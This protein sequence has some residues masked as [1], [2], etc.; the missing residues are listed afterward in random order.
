MFGENLIC[1]VA[2]DRAAHAVLVP[3]MLIQPLLENALH[4]GGQTSRMPLKVVVTTKVIDGLLEVV[5]ANTG[6]WDEPDTTRSPV[7]RRAARDRH[8]QALSDA[9]REASRPWTVT[10]ETVCAEARNSPLR[11]RVAGHSGE[12]FWGRET[13]T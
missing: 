12:C 13:K 3:P 4:Y 9:G 10:R 2:C 11:G 7:A 6:R 5:V 1:R 8:P